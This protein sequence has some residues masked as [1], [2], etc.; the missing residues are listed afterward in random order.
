MIKFYLLSIVSKVILVKT[1]LYILVLATGCPEGAL[2][3]GIGASATTNRKNV[4]K[5][6]MVVVGR[7]FRSETPHGLRGALRT[8]AP[9][10]RG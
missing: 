3:G 5:F 1:I 2:K 9:C 7:F 6:Q 8:A 4:V 10:G